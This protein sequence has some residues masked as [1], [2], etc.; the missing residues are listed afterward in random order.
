AIAELQRDPHA[1]LIRR[2]GLDLDPIDAAELEAHPREGRSH[3]R[4][5]PLSLPRGA[6]PVA[7]LERIV[8]HA[9]VEPAPTDHLR[10]VAR[11]QPVDEVLAEVELPPEAPE[12]LHLLVERLR[13][14]RGPGHPRTQMIDARVDRL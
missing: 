7:D 4:R 14:F 8:A 1:A 3:L 5:Q 11:E 9:Q 13:L 6:D 2:L 12:Q 10:L